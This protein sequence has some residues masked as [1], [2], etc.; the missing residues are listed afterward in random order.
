MQPVW[1]NTADAIHPAGVLQALSK[2]PGLIGPGHD[3]AKECPSEQSSQSVISYTTHS[4][5]DW[6]ESW[7]LVP[8]EV[9]CQ[10]EPVKGS[11]IEYA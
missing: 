10:V 5:G 4:G 8:D 6:L 2:S 7:F 9:H 1:C 3:S 11:D